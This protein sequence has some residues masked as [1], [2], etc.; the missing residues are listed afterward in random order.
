VEDRLT[1]HVCCHSFFVAMAAPSANALN[2]AQTTVGWTSGV[3]VARDKNPQSPA[4]AREKGIEQA[5][6]IDLQQLPGHYENSS[7]GSRLEKEW[8]KKIRIAW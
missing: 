5:L 1:F 7:G 4:V 6:F 3:K 8:Q 2:F